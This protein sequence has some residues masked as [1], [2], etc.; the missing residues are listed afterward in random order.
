MRKPLFSLCAAA[1]ASLLLS[2]GAQA[3]S[4]PWGYSATSTEIYNSN[5]PLKTSSVKFNGSSAVATGD[6]GI[7]IYNLETTSTVDESTPD[8]F[9]DVGF[10]LEVTLTDI[11]AGGLGVPSGKVKFSGLYSA[12]NVSKSSSLPDGN[13]WVGA[14]KSEVTLGSKESGWRKYA[15][16]IASFTPP[17]Q[18]GGAP[19]SIQAV[20]RISDG[21]DPGGSGGDPPPNDVPEPTSVVL[22]GLGLPMLLMARRRLKKAQA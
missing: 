1:L 11:K 8:T 21:T 15:V 19:G 17:G 12:S 5:T 7:I 9:K 18:P 16:E 22:A 6:S 13:S 20:V 14:T 4:I 3:T 2:T 10:D